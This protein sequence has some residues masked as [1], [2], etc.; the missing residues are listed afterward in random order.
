MTRSPPS[1]AEDAAVARLLTAL[2]PL[3]AG[4]LLA[5]PPPTSPA[6]GAVRLTRDGRFKQHLHFWPDGKRLLFTR[7]HR[8]KMGLWTLAAD[9]S[10]LRPLL[11]PD[12]NTPHFDGHY[13][14]DGKRVVYVHDALHGTDGKLQINVCDADGK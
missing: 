1:L 10:D 3:F 9:G 6:P 7:I 2:T 5:P 11:V 4:V 8:G 14:P 13:S 12:P